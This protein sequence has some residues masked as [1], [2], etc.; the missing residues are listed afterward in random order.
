MAEKY[1]YNLLWVINGIPL[2]A[3]PEELRNEPRAFAHYAPADIDRIRPFLREF[4]KRYADTKVIKA[5]EIGNELNAKRGW[6]PQEHGDY[7]RAIYEETKRATNDMPV[8]GISLSGGIP[9]DYMDKSLRAGLD[10]NMDIASLHLYEIGSLEG[11]QSIE[12][13]IRLFKE[14]L[15]DFGLEELP[16]WNTESGCPMDIRQDGLILSQE[17][18]NRQIIQHPD[19]NPASA[20]RVG[21]NWRGASEL[22]GTAWMIRA[23]YQQF[24]MGI[25]KNF[26]FQWSAGPHF[27]WV[28]D[29]EPGGNTMPKISVVAAAVMSKMLQKYD[30]APTADQ[31]EIESKG[32]W[33]AYAHRFE[34]TEG[35]MTTVYVTPAVY[36]GPGDGV[37]PG[38]R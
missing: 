5:V 34:G 37:G 33:K 24:A 19:F 6:T 36:V 22:L 1:G 21:S 31:P 17:E 30:P 26:I 16:I 23:S 12:R 10:E 35:S 18:L 3:L 25:E 32:E 2:W 14:K 8:I 27:S 20:W 28:H 15:Q 38:S 7:A 4:W 9:I 11:N 29:W 13:K